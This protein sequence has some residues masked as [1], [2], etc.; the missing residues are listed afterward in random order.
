MSPATFPCT[1]P[2]PGE[3]LEEVRIHPRVSLG[4][5]YKLLGGQLGTRTY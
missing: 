5:G 1:R 4:A 2:V 3:M